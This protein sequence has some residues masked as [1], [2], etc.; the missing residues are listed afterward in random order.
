MKRL[1]AFVVP[2]VLVAGSG[3][4]FYWFTADPGLVRQPAEKAEVEDLH[5]EQPF[6]RVK[7]TAHYPVVVKQRTVPRFPWQEPEQFYLFPLFPEHKPD[8]RAV[9]ILVRTK[10]APE[11]Y[12][13]YE[14]MTLEGR[15]YP[16]TPDK[17]P[18]NTEIEFGK[19]SPYFFTDDLLIFEPWEI[20]SEDG[21]WVIEDAKPAE[22]D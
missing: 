18:Y 7:G 10:R 19:R 3:A 12:V 20:V 5:I 2:F 11:K 13:A 21:T 14:V 15:L 17:M 16:P 6:V 9:R 4:V 22:E 8:A 1:L